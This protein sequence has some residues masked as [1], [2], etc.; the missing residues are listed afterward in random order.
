MIQNHCLGC[1][2]WT[3]EWPSRASMIYFPETLD[4]LGRPSE[5]LV[6]LSTNMTLVPAFFAMFSIVSCCR[7]LTKKSSISLGGYPVV[8]DISPTLSTH[9]CVILALILAI[10]RPLSSFY[11][12]SASARSTALIL[13]AS[14]SFWA[15]CFLLSEALMSFIDFKISSGGTIFRICAL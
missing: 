8:L 9:P 2:W 14:P 10:P 12:A 4:D 1:S 5:S 15:A 7:T 13:A 3:K 11:W 6:D